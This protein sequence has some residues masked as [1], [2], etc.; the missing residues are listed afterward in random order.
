MSAAGCQMEGISVTE[1][2]AT[3]KRTI[4]NMIDEGELD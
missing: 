2:I 1:A 3:V 4:D